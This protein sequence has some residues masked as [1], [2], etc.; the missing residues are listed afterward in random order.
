MY[1]D[2]IDF[3]LPGYTGPKVPL[4]DKIGDKQQTYGSVMQRDYFT[5]GKAFRSPFVRTA[6][7]RLV[8]L[9]WK[10]PFSCIA[11]VMQSNRFIIFL[12]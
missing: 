2:V 7:K 11:E 5:V 4:R 9:R 12:R 10:I 8:H 3:P 6:S 1:D